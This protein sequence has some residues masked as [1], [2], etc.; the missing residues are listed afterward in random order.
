MEEKI[1]EVEETFLIKKRGLIIAGTLENNALNFKVGDKIKFYC[2][3]NSVIS[4]EVAGLEMINFGLSFGSDRSGKI[5]FSVRSL[6]DKKEILKGA[7]VF[8]IK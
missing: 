5:A 3:D 1:L 4:S 2:S 6:N 8:L 7:N